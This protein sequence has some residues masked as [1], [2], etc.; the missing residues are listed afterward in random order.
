LSQKS[1]KSSKKEAIILKSSD[2][3]KKKA[4]KI[5]GFS[6]IKK[7]KD[8]VILDVGQISGL[9]DYFV[10][11]S[12]ESGRQVKAI[13]EETARQC[14]KNKIKIHHY[15]N[16]QEHSWI[17]VDFFDVILHIFS[18]DARKFYDLEHLWREAKKIKEKIPT[19]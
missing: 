16:D 17:F 6:A 2:T 13:Y 18:E 7:A 8:I 12:G 4:L 11:C 14:K 5:A 15:E 19:P 3:V 9:C 1:K 10:I